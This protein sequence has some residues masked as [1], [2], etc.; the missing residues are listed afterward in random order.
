MNIAA[1]LP[2]EHLR[3][4]R[5]SLRLALMPCGDPEPL[6]DADPFSDTP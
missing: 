6:P 2:E 5:E 3:V 4:I 1:D